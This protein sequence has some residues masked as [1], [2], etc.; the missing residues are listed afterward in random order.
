MQLTIQIVNYRSRHYLKECLFSILENLP[1]DLD[2][3]IIVVNNDENEI[4]PSLPDFGPRITLRVIEMKR[5]IG[6]GR[7]HNTA[8]QNSSGEYVLFLN[9]DAKILPGFFEEIINVFLS[10][11]KIGIASPFLID[12]AGKIQAGNFGEKRTPLSTIFGK[13]LSFPEDIFQEENI[14]EADW[15][16]GGAM[17]VRKNMFESLGGFD[18]NFF[19]YF[20]DVDLCLRAKN[21]GYKIAVVPRARVFHAG[22][23]SFESEREKK[24][25]YYASQDYYHQKHFGPVWAAAMKILRLPLYVKNAS[26]FFRKI[27]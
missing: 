21:A 14:F 23:K 9:P 18:E 26:F 16:S 11:E 22:G 2:V 4:A 20:E 19:M 5:N 8:F 3:E 10:D 15:V 13:I 27:I 12:A 6:F 1:A 17:C 25:Y 24:K 7:A